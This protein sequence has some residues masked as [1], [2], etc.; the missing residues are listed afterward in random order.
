M[1]NGHVKS[2]KF[3]NSKVFDFFFWEEKNMNYT[4]IINSKIC[5]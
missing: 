4:V 5:I 2:L 3:P 1:I